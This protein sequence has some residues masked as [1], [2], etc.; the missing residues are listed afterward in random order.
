M[1]VDARMVE[2][3]DWRSG[4]VTGQRQISSPNYTWY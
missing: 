1:L 2:V 4:D 3:I